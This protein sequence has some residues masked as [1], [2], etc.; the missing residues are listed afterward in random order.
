MRQKSLISNHYQRFLTPSK[1]IVAHPIGRSTPYQCFF[2]QSCHDSANRASPHSPLNRGD[3]DRLC[4]A[5]ARLHPDSRGPT[6]L[7]AEW[8]L[9]QEDNNHVAVCH[10]VRELQCHG[11]H[12]EPANCLPTAEYADKDGA[13]C[14]EPLVSH[15]KNLARDAEMF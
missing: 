5:Y 7:H 4:G 11:G 13:L 3:K 8:A 1:P 10:R 9:R 12:D 6:R 14:Q 2:Q 15:D